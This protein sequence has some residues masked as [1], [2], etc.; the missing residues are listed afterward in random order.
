MVSAISLNAAGL[1]YFAKR[2]EAIVVGFV[3]SRTESANE[4]SFTINV[5]RV[6]SGSVNVPAL[7]VSVVHPWVRA[8]QLLGPAGTIDQPLFGIWFLARGGSGTWDVLSPRP[9]WWGTILGLF[10]PAS[11]TPPSGPYAY[12][13]G[14]PIVDALV[15]ET[16]AGFLSAT[17]EDSN[18]RWILGAFDSID[19]ASVRNVL[20]TLAASGDPKLQAIALTGSLERTI[21]GAIST[22]AALLPSLKNDPN[23]ALV[24]SA[25]RDSSRDPTPASIQQLVWFV[26]GVP[27]DCD[28]RAA[29]VRALA[30]IHTKETLPFLAS[31]LSSA[32]ATEQER[33]LYGLSSFANGCP[34][35]TQANATSMA[36]LQCTGASPYKTTQTA[37]NLAFRAGTPEQEFP[38]ISFWQGWW[39]DH[40]EL[41]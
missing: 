8:G 19:T 2:A 18:P 11:S 13:V 15:N 31:L 26:A 34:I 27:A 6:L 17:N 25:L 1:D 39:N 32:D 35:E 33:A 14:A 20:A 16:A 7:T 38:L 22:L 30:A 21:P 9:S 28:I 12:A 40:P 37:A 4:V 29:A 41:H 5:S 3:N 10:I 36:F 23:E 24:V